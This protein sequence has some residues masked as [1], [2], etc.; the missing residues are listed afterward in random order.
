MCDGVL[1]DVV[2]IGRLRAQRPWLVLILLSLGQ[3]V[4]NIDLTL[5]SISNCNQQ[6]G[7]NESLQEHFLPQFGLYCRTG[8]NSHL[9]DKDAH[10]ESRIYMFNYKLDTFGSSDPHCTANGDSCTKVR[11]VLIELA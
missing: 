7:T 6:K 3:V 9:N 1:V 2:V 4:S 10:F 8:A 11:V 5:C